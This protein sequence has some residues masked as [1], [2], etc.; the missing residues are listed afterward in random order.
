[1]KVIGY[2]IAE[3]KDRDNL[4]ATKMQEYSEKYG[5]YATKADAWSAVERIEDE[6]NLSWDALF[7]VGIGE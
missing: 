2:F 5:V 4:D 6:Q 7:I 3:T 1:M